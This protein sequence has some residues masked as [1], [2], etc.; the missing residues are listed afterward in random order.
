MSA[1]FQKIVSYIGP[2]L[3]KVLLGLF[4]CIKEIFKFLNFMKQEA[5][6]EKDEKEI[7]EHNDHVKDVCDNG[8]VE[9][10]INL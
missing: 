8:D 4:S 2:L 7:K 9:D 3:G 5:K 10:L 1:I 6:D